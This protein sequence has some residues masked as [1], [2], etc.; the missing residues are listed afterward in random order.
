MGSRALTYT[1]TGSE[2]GSAVLATMALPAFTGNFTITAQMSTTPTATHNVRYQFFRS[3]DSFVCRDV[4]SSFTSGENPDVLTGTV[5]TPSASWPATNFDQFRLLLS[6]SSWAGRVGATIT[7]TVSGANVSDPNPCQYGTR[8]S[9][10]APAIAFVTD[11]TIAAAC[12]LIGAPWLAVLFAPLIGY[13]I[14][15][16][17]LCGSGP[18]TMPTITNNDL[19]SDISSRVA[20]LQ[21]T[22]W[23]SVCECV[24]GTPAPIPYPP[25]SLTQPTGWPSDPVYNCDPANLCATLTLILKRL[26]QLSQTATADLTLTTLIQRYE[27][28]MAYISSISRGPLTG[29]GTFAI[30]R[31]VGLRLEVTAGL[32]TRQLEGNPPYVWNIGWVSVLD[33]TRML[34]EHRISQQY[35]EWFPQEMPLAGTVNYWLYPGVSLQITELHAEP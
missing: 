35:R 28:P 12:T 13:A 5:G 8:P 29:S 15:V 24:P 16:G 20:A 27:V 25:P 7:V 10:S 6:S 19:L 22:L 34:E 11:A 14:D 31:C 26:D 23:Y 30:A 9:A 3:S 32:P 18:P 21:A 33:G 1:Y 2:T 4:S 17:A